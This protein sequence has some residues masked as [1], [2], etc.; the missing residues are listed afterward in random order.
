MWHGFLQATPRQ[1]RAF[2]TGQKVA[3]H[4]DAVAATDRRK[5]RWRPNSVCRF[6][7]APGSTGRSGEQH[8]AN[9]WVLMVRDTPAP[10]YLHDLIESTA[11]SIP[12][13]LY[14]CDR[15]GAR[16]SLFFN[17]RASSLRGWR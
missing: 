8:K 7:T 12:A 2:L 3:G 17:L 6:S 15:P 5:P 14:C 1:A 13:W 4:L 16:P 10:A 9:D 11:C